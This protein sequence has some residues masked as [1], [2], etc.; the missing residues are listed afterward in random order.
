MRRKEEAPTAPGENGRDVLRESSSWF[1]GLGIL[2]ALLGVF[3]LGSATAATRASVMIL[4]W[5]LVIGGALQTAHAVWRHGW[6]GSLLDLA[7]G[8]LF[9]VVGVMAVTHPLQSTVALAL[10]LAVFLVVHGGIRILAA[11]THRFPHRFW[12]LTHG[13]ITLALGLW[14]WATWPESGLWML[15][16]FVGVDLLLEGVTLALLGVAARQL[17]ELPTERGRGR[18]VVTPPPREPAPERPGPARRPVPA[19]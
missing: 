9:L 11:L 1:L 5:A 6:R 7:S 13:V 2:L 15:G 8:V 18:P 16:V 14:L 3:A 17:P 19:T 12:V 10:V 4:G